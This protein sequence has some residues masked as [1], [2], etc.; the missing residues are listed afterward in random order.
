MENQGRENWGILETQLKGISSDIKL[1]GVIWNN[2]TIFSLDFNQ[3]YV[4]RVNAL[5]Y[6]I[7]FDAKLNFTG[8]VLY[9]TNLKIASE[10]QDTYLLLSGWTKGNVFVNSFNIGRYWSKG[11]QKTLYIPGPLLKSGDNCILIFELH[12]PG[13]APQFIDGPI[14]EVK[15]KKQR[16]LS[17]SNFHN[18]ISKSH[19]FL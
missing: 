10:P 6:W 5:D 1:D 9:R 17:K 14:L 8:P 12:S 3:S 16:K 7:P 13:A 19:F 11:P 18:Q 2:F 4:D 15:P